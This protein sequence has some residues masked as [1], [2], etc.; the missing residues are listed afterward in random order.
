MATI[1]KGARQLQIAVL[2]AAL[3]PGLAHSQQQAPDTETEAKAPLA[4]ERKRERSTSTQPSLS[5]VENWN[6]RVDDLIAKL[7]VLQNDAF[8]ADDLF[9][10]LDDALRARV[11][12]LNNLLKGAKSP[13][14]NV[15][16]AG[17]PGGMRTIVDLDES[18][19]AMYAARLRLIE[20]ITPSL[21]LEATATDVFGVQQLTM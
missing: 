15:R 14:D 20:H 19:E 3:V 1:I 10:E 8:D 9:L 6:G 17:L 18:V 5:S 21:H 7:V 16:A 4:E 12:L 11:T 13:Q 2:L